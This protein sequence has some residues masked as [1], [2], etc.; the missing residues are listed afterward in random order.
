MLEEFGAA[1]LQM[2]GY[3]YWKNATDASGFS[4]LPSC[5]YS[6]CTS[7]YWSISEKERYVYTW[8]IGNDATEF[9]EAGKGDQLPIRCIQDDP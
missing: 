9:C 1:G 8:K 5:Y 3:R 2:R 7:S 4:A 6:D